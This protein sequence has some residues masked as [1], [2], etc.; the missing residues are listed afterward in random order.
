M[1][2]VNETAP[3]IYAGPAALAQ[4]EAEASK[5]PPKRFAPD[6]L[7]LELQVAHLR[8][9]LVVAPKEEVRF[10]LVGVLVE[11][12]GDTVRLVATDGHRMLVLADDAAVRVDVPGQ[13]A[14]QP[15]TTPER[16]I[17][18][19]PALETVL[20]AADRLSTIC[21]ATFE[22]TPAKPARDGKPAE[23][24]GLWRI[25][26]TL[27]ANG[28]TL[29]VNAIDGVFPEWTRVL[30]SKPHPEAKPVY[31]WFDPHYVA[32][33]ERINGFLMGKSPRKGGGPGKAT[34]MA[35]FTPDG[36]GVALSL[37]PGAL[38]VCMP[39]RGAEATC[40]DWLREMIG[41]VA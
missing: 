4:A 6:K 35:S 10:Y 17:I 18:P 3:D 41:G 19:R 38:Y 40:G 14:L 16:I 30:P 25:T 31:Q 20:K 2:T 33:A 15:F 32:D 8:A 13:T 5:A 12:R 36:P 23:A 29:Q 1:T 34:C 11:H 7:K 37:P 9:L 26:L 28:T 39:M 24:A 21:I 22:R 27:P